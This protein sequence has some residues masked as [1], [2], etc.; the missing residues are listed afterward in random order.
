MRLFEVVRMAVNGPKNEAQAFFDE[1]RE[2]ATGKHEEE[3][4]VT[5][6]TDADLARFLRGR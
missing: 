6:A 2:R 1:L 4:K 5:L 3:S